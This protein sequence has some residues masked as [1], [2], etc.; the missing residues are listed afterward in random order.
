MPATESIAAQIAGMARSYKSRPANAVRAAA[1]VAA[2]SV[3][4][5]AEDTNAASNAEGAK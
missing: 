1:S 4:P 5:C 2:I 3:S